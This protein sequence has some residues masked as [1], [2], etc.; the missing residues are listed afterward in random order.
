MK[1]CSDAQRRTQK[2]AAAQASKPTRV[3]SKRPRVI[4]VQIEELVLHGFAATD[5]HLVA[6]AVERELHRLFS[7]QPLPAR[8][9][10]DT[11]FDHLDAGGFTMP[12]EAPA[13]QIGTN[14]ARTLSSRLAAPAAVASNERT[15]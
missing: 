5:R 9:Q 10:T 7:E 12:I 4:E 6:D 8:W 11:E 3:G 14:L 2:E 15:R 1:T 13:E